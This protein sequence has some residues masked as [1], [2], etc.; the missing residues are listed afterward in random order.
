[1]KRSEKIAKKLSTFLATVV[2]VNKKIM[3]FESFLGRQYSDNPRAMYEYIKEHYPEYKCY[4][5]VDVAEQKKFENKGL[6][7]IK[8]GTIRWFFTM[9]R[10]KYWISNSRIPLWVIKPKKTIYVQTW[11]GTPLK[12]LAIDM[13]DANIYPSWNRPIPYKK[14]FSLES[15]RWN[16][17]ISPNKYST[18]IFR[19][20]F[21]FENEMIESGYPRND[22]LI[23]GN[24]E[25][26]INHIKKALNI[27]LDKKIIMYAPTWRDSFTFNLPLSLTN[28]KKELGD[29]YYVIF[30]LHYLV[31]HTSE[32]IG[33]EDFIQNVTS[34]NDI[35]DLYLISDVLITDYSSV[36]FDYAVL[37][38][39]MIFH[40]F[41]MD[42]YKNDLRG[43]YFDFEK[44]APGP[45]VTTTDELIDAVKR[46]DQ[47]EISLEFLDQFAS[48]EDGK[49]TERVV[50]RIL[51]K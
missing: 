26:N 12:K 14:A 20:C 21:D 3:V 45:I 29:E 11:H 4:W 48:L 41:D 8:K 7:I 40:C 17:L 28:M 13:D 38:R 37:K 19:R 9:A 5:S 10:A 47:Q 35:S 24:N 23:N 6:N 33:H 30:R 32:L 39:P 36:F 15:S 22:Y 49:A 43:F 51:E 50:E 27:P 2:P 42:L 34:Y 46:V 1:M 44:K 31:K 18:N 25:E 16:Y